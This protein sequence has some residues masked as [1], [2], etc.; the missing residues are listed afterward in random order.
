[1]LLS[2]FLLKM[3]DAKLSHTM[4]DHANKRMCLLLRCVMMLCLQVG[5]ELGGGHQGAVYELLDGKGK[6][7]G[8][9]LKV[10]QSGSKCVGG[11]LGVDALYISCFVTVPAL[12]LF[13]ARDKGIIQSGFVAFCLYLCLLK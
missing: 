4:Q 11:P 5:K 7:S 3:Q 8:Q 10:G 2:C 1:M 12:I 13:K 6:D 9:V